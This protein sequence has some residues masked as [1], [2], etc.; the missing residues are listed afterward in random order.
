MNDCFI[1]LSL[2]LFFLFLNPRPWPE[3]C[4][5]LGSVRPFVLSSFCP[6]IFSPFR[7]SLQKLFGIGLLDFFEAWHGVRGPC[8]TVR[9]RA[10]FFEK[11]IF[12]PNMEKMDQK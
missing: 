4:Y 3:G 1:Y 8:C 11:N 7:P 6:S 9:D 10:G 2:F 12:A 5:E